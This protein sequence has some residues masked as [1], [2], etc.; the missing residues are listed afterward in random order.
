MIIERTK[1]YAAE[2]MNMTW[3]IEKF[4]SGTNHNYKEGIKYYHLWNKS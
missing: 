3:Q 1:I 4:V 2:Q